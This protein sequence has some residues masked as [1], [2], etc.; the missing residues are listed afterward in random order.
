MTGAAQSEIVFSD[1]TPGTLHQLSTLLLE[2][3]ASTQ[4]PEMGGMI[5]LHGRWTDPGRPNGKSYYG[6]KVVDDGGAQAKVEILTSLV[7]SRGIVPGQNVVV[8]GRLAVRTSN[9]GVEVRLV[10]ADIQLGEQEEAVQTDA[11]RQGRMTID[12][13]RALPLGRVSFPDKDCVSVALIQSTSAAAQVA[14]DCMAELSQLGTAVDVLPVRIN[15]LD[16]VAIAA[17]IREAAADVVAIIRGGGSSQ[18]FEV[19]DDARVIVALAEQRAHRVVGLGHSGNTS[20][21]ELVADVTANTPA[22]AG[23]YIRER[24]QHRQRM[25]GDMGRELRLVKERAENLE[26]ERNIAQSQLQTAS[27][28]LAKAQG[29]VPYWTVAAAFVAGAALVWVLN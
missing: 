5:R 21:L 9:Y 14:S 17:A 20:L 4:L 27:E 1:V 29:G 7:S 13:L 22:Q 16:P 18:D 23:T 19:F 28:L 15:M 2:R 11:T 6:A 25:L 24:V 3:L 8:T 12:R 10:G 26:K